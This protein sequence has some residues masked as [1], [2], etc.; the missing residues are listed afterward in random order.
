MKITTLITPTLLYILTACSCV[1]AQ[2][3]QPAHEYLHK[4]QD[5]EKQGMYLDAA[6]LYGRAVQAE[7]ENPTSSEL[8]LVTE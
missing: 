1:F 8:N 6:N 5:L 3:H 4:A 7:K 2:D